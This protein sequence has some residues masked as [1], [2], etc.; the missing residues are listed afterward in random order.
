M[1]NCFFHLNHGQRIGIKEDNRENGKIQKIMVNTKKDTLGFKTMEA[2]FGLEISK[3]KN[4][5]FFVFINFNLIFQALCKRIEEN[6][7]R[8]QLWLHPYH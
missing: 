3:L 1:A 6:L 2:L 5:K 8:P 7:L 4:Y